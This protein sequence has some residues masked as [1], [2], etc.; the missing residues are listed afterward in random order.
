MMY[1][2]EGFSHFGN[3][4]GFGFIFMILFW[5]LVIYGVYLVLKKSNHF[6][7]KSSPMEIL[8][9]RYAKGEI[10]KEEFEE[11]KKNIK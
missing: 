7:E 6:N 11:M 8:K 9:E 5:V 10:L 1:D 4:Y 2:Y 3:M